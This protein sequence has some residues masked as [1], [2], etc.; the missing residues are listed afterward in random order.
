MYLNR[1]ARP[2]TIKQFT[3]DFV[4][5]VHALPEGVDHAIQYI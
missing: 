5:L 1:I 2:Q 3:A 4:D